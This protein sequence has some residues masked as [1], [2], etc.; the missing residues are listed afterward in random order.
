MCP[1]YKYVLVSI[2]DVPL[3]TQISSES[4]NS[5]SSDFCLLPFTPIPVIYYMANV[6]R[7]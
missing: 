1:T 3:N 6:E 4:R 2:P 7:G 5:K